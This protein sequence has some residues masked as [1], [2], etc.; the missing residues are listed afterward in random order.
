M[1]HHFFFF[2]SAKLNYFLDGI[3]SHPIEFMFNFIIVILNHERFDKNIGISECFSAC[4]FSGGSKD[5]AC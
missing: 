5:I 4:K 2:Q 1:L 3:A